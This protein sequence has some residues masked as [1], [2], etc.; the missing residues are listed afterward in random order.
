M[1]VNIIEKKQFSVKK[2]IK[3][4]T[5]IN[6]MVFTA[7]YGWFA[8]IL[9]IGESNN[10]RC[11]HSL[12]PVLQ[13]PLYYRERNS[14]WF[15]EEVTQWWISTVFWTDHMNKN[16]DV[17]VVLFLDDYPDHNID[18]SNL[19]PSFK[20]KFLLPNVTNKHHPSYI[21]MIVDIK[22]G[23]KSFS[24]RTFLVNFDTPGG[25]EESTR[26]QSRQR[27]VIRG[28]LDCMKILKNYGIINFI[29]IAYSAAGVSHIYF[30]LHGIQTLTK[31]LDV[32]HCQRKNCEQRNIRRFVPIDG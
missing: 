25:Y 20:I 27:P 32:H 18:M 17:N 3:D 9:L 2:Q 22:F 26:L 14:L 1:Y 6:A 16:G 7:A 8:P 23:C 28:N 30:Q 10:P 12:D 31:F 21:G 4:K 11:F 19:F 15:D 29:V 5:I 24:L 13:T